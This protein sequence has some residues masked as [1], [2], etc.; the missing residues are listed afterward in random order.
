MD[1]IEQLFMKG[2]DSEALRVIQNLTRF[3]NLKDLFMKTNI[4]NAK[5][6]VKLIIL[7]KYL[8]ALKLIDPSIAIDNVLLYYSLLRISLKGKGRE[9]TIRAL[10]ALNKP[11]EEKRLNSEGL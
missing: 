3:T 6:L 7:G 2:E 5:P 8:K 10:E 11:K 4:D 9:D 1:E